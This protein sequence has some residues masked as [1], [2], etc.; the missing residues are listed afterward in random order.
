MLS[1]FAATGVRGYSELEWT[2]ASE[3][4]NAGFNLYRS[5]AENSDGIRV[6]EELVAAKGDG[7]MGA[8]YA[9]AD[10]NVT[11]GHTYYY[12]LESVDLKGGSDIVEAA[13]VTVGQKAAPSPAG[14]RLTQNY[15]NPFN[16]STEIVYEL[17]VGCQVRLDIYDA[18]GRRVA[19]LVDEYQTAG[20]KVVRWDG[21]G[22]NASQAPSGIYFCR[23]KAGSFEGTKKLIMIR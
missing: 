11:P 14:F 8:S 22:V 23:L 2:T 13:V 5:S 6:N 18:V 1:S 19:T 15:P 12:W 4:D 3:V 17:P 20:S 16:P 9:F 21:K 10:H 7:A